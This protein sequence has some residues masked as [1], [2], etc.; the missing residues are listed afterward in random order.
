MT[1]G[2]RLEEARKRKG[3]SIREV[4][5]A[6]KIRGNYLL[7]MEDNTMDIDLPEIYRRGF[8]RNYAIFLK[9]DPD[10]FITDYEAQQRSRAGLRERPHGSDDRE[11]F[12]RME[13]SS[14]EKETG[15]RSEV[16]EKPRRKSIASGFSFRRPE[17]AEEGEERESSLEIGAFLTENTLY[18]KIAA[19]LMGG[20][21]VF[22]LVFLIVGI[23]RSGAPDTALDES[24]V[25]TASENAAA[26]ESPAAQDARPASSITL[27]A[28]EDV[29]VIVDSLVTQERLFQGRMSTGEVQLIG[30]EDG[31]V[32][33][34]FSRGAALE[35]ER[36]NQPNVRPDE[37]GMGRVRIP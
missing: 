15:N 31:A 24:N 23:L 3:I 18:L 11:V 17:D 2:E 29:T 25:V 37:P 13:L 8:L 14:N 32:L 12:G 10:K 27:R 30:K 1:I 5:E 16:R 19:G 34:K 35:I 6:T 9:L 22:F 4:A 20:L 21:L 26:G 36:P 28:L 33:I 7:S